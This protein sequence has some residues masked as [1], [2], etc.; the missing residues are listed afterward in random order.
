MSK[1]NLEECVSVA[2]KLF[3]AYDRNGNGLLDPKELRAYFK[4]MI[5]AKAGQEIMGI[6]M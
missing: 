2:E 3:V 5:E 1:S 6:S 4:Q